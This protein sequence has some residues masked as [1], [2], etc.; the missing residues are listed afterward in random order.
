MSAWTARWCR[1]PGARPQ[2]ARLATLLGNGLSGVI[3]ILDEP[4]VGL[5]PRDTK[6]LL[7]MLKRLCQQGNTV[8]VV[9]HDPETMLA[10]DHLIDLG[11]G[12]RRAGRAGMCRRHTPQH[13]KN[14][15]DSLTG[16]YLSGESQISIPTKRRAAKHLLTLAHTRVHNLKDISVDFPLGALTC[17]TGVSGSGKSSLISDA[18]VPALAAA[19]GGYALDCGRQRASSRDGSSLTR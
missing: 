4:S 1:C 15:P 17:V 2:R 6:Q 5:H 9:E 10:A 12:C 11:P 13:V 8:V 14:A 16:H 3:Y 19:L 7:E 18:L